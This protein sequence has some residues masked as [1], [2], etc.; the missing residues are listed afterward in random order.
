MNKRIVFFLVFLSLILTSCS[1]PVT[2]VPET[3]DPPNSEFREK[4]QYDL[5]EY[6][7]MGD[8]AAIRFEFA[9]D[10]DVCTDEE[11]EAAVFQVLLSNATFTEKDTAAE[12]YNK[13]QFDFF[14]IY[15]G[16]TQ[17]EFNQ[18]NYSLILGN[19]TNPDLEEK[20]SEALIG[21]V[22]GEERS[23]EYTYPDSVT[24]GTWRGKTVR[25]V[26]KVKKIYQHSIPECNDEFAKSLSGFQFQTAE[27]F[28]LSVK[29]DILDRKEDEMV[30]AFW[31]EF[32]KTVQVLKYPGIELGLYKQDF[33]KYHEQM[34]EYVGMKFDAYLSAYLEIDASQFEKEAQSYA[35]ELCRN[36]MAFTALSRQ[37]GI[38]I[39]EEE[40]QRELKKAYQNSGSGFSTVEKFES[41][42]GK[43]NLM[44]NLIWDKAMV[45][46][47]RMAERVEPEETK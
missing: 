28:R 18:N 17:E 21:A 35:E 24:S 9:D 40:Y 22:V 32:V 5:S 23:V 1:N 33:I 16:K 43:S 41:Y 42:Y 31:L 25:A 30:S 10:P 6:I 26:A 15:E 4:Y 11:L 19:G 44:Q 39:S 36:E 38:T 7:Q 14:L 29:E 3:M 37:F 27:E 45:T 8:P 12:R 20:L 2:T 34:A 13:V 46:V 47:A